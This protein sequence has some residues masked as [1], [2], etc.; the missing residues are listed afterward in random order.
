MD[1]TI[2]FNAFDNPYWKM[3]AKAIEGSQRVAS[4]LASN[5]NGEHTSLHSVAS[6]ATESCI[7]YMQE[8]VKHP[9]LTTKYS[10]AI[11]KNYF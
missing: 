6:D 7:K 3:T 4:H 2:N 1:R 10:A 8:C 11:G 5:L 9:W